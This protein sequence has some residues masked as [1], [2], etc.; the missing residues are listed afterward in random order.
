V[1][2]TVTDPNYSGSASGTLVVSKAT[3]T[4]S[5]IDEVVTYD[6]APH[7]ASARS[8]PGGLM[9]GVTYNGGPEPTNAGSYAVVATVND[10]NYEGTGTGTLTINKA[11]ATV[12]LGNLAQECD[13]APKAVSVTTVPPGL[14]FTVTYNGSTV[15][16]RTAGTYVVIATVTNPNYAGSATGSLII[17]SHEETSSTRSNGV[18]QVRRPTKGTGEYAIKNVAAGPVK[19]VKV[20]DSKDGG[21]T[22]GPW[23]TCSGTTLSPGSSCSATY[24]IAKGKLIKVQY[25]YPVGTSADVIFNFN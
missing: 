10:L 6:G 5:V 9:L 24:S 19:I 14:A 18:V 2:A 7:G 15:P 16:P 22:W 21:A 4:V 23:T 17:S 8:I 12:T 20:Y 3:A 13:D 11:S 1:V 25:Q